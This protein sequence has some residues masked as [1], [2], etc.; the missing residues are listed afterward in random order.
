[1]FLFD[2]NRRGRALLINVDYLESELQER[3]V[4]K[5][6]KP[7]ASQSS[8]KVTSF[9]SMDNQAEFMDGELIISTRL[10]SGN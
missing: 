7:L 3:K 1:M 9:S 5:I 4:E 8:R 6:T 2:E 10:N